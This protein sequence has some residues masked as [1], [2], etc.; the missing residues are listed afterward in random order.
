[1]ERLETQSAEPSPMPHE[2]LRPTLP[3]AGR[4]GLA[5]APCAL[6]EG[7][8]GSGHAR[9]EVP[10]LVPEGLQ[11]PG[12]VWNCSPPKGHTVRLEAIISLGLAPPRPIR[13][14]ATSGEVSDTPCPTPTPSAMHTTGPQDTSGSAGG[15]KKRIPGLRNRKISRTLSPLFQKWED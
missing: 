9:R 6:S 3:A 1:M 5:R 4:E 10:H 13:V 8:A 15:F 12:Q 11:S 14:P 2:G 7:V